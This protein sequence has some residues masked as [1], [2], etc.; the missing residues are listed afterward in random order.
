MRLAACF[1]VPVEIVEPCGFVWGDKRLKRAGMDYTDGVDLTRHPSWDE[2]DRDR[3]SGDGR[4]VL[5]TTKA[6]VAHHDFSFAPNDKL[7]F[8]RESAGVPDLVH[9]AADHRIKIPM[10]PQ[11]RSL[12]LAQ[13]AAIGLAEALRQTGGWPALSPVPTPH[14]AT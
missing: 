13:A 4:L 8:G 3:K 11:T 2:F 6:D 1:G 7:L 9:Q 5:F 14:T 10:A 12:N